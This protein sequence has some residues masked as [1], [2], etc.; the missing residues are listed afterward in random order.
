MIRDALRRVPRRTLAAAC[1]AAVLAW[2]LWAW[3]DPVTLF[4]AASWAAGAAGFTS[5]ATAL[6]Y[7][8]IAAAVYG[9]VTSRRQ[10]RAKAAAQRAAYNA[11]LE[12]RSVTLLQA[13]PPWRIVYG[14]SITGGDIVAI[15]TTDKTGTRSDATTY[16]KADA[17]KHLVIV[18]AAHECQAVNELYV[19]GVP[20][21]T[22]DGSGWVTAGEFYSTL[23][24]HREI[25]IVAGG[26]STQP[27]APT[28]LKSVRANPPDTTLPVDASYTIT[29]GG[30]T[31]NN[32]SG[33]NAV[34]TFTLPVPTPSVRAS[35]H[36][37]TAAQTVDAY[38]NGVA[39]TEWTAD[40]RL[41]GL[42]YSVV[43]LDLENPRFQGGPPNITADVSGRKVLDTRT[44]T[45]AYS[46]NP[47]L[48]VRD[49]LTAPWGY[50]CAAADIDTTACNTAANACDALITLTIGGS[51]TPNQPTYT[52]NGVLT[53]A[54]S[55]EALLEQLVA[56]MAGFAVY[57]AKW[58]I[59]AGAWTA[60]VLALTDDDLVGQIEIVQADA[61]LDEA[62][63]G[64]RGMHVPRGKAVPVEF[65]QYQNATFVAADGAELW[66]DIDLPWVDNK[67]RARNLARIFVE[68]A[69][70]A[71]AIRYPA[72]LRAWPLQVG[73]RVTV[74]S[75]E[76]G[77]ATKNFRVTDWQFG[78][79]SPVLLT[80]QEDEAA[81]YDLADAAT[82][83]PAPNTN[84]PNPWAVAALGGV[85]VASG[86]A[87]LVKL[88][89]GTIDT[90]AQV[91]WTAIADPY[92]TDGSGVVRLRWRRLARDPANLWHEIEV[93]GNETKAIIAGL[94][95]YDI[96]AIEAQAINGLG[97][98]GVPV[99]VVHT[100]VG[101]TAPPADVAS[102]AAAAITGAIRLTWAPNTEADYAAT[103]LRLGT[104]W[105]SG[106][107]LD[108]GAAG[109]TEVVGNAYLWA[110]PAPGSY[111]V[112]A[113]HRDTT[114]NLSTSTTSLAVTVT[115]TDIAVG[116]G[117]LLRN[118]S[119]E[120]DA[121]AD[122]LGDGW[123]LFTNGGAAVTYKVAGPD[124]RAH[125]A[126][127]QRIE[128]NGATGTS[129]FIFLRQDAEARGVIGG[130]PMVLSGHFQSDLNTPQVRL[131][132]GFYN[133]AA[134]LISSL[135]S[136]WLTL[137]G[138]QNRLQYAFDAPSGTATVRAE[139]VVGNVGNASASRIYIDALQLEIGRAMTAYAPRADE[140][141]AGQVGTVELAAEAA[142]GLATA[143][144]TLGTS[145]N[146]G[147]STQTRATATWVN[148]TGAA[149]QVQIEAYVPLSSLSWN[150]SPP[151]VAR[152]SYRYSSTT[153]GTVTRLMCD[154]AALQ[155]AGGSLLIG[156]SAEQ[157]TLPAGET[158]T[159]ELLWELT[160]TALAVLNPGAQTCATR[161]AA[162]K[163]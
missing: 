105:A 155:P 104:V 161:I 138:G 153:L 32:T 129:D 7:M 163:R 146:N 42:C 72:K 116:G 68:R 127:A 113:R 75:T 26:S 98:R 31:I 3:A 121:N 19:D 30:L 49:F 139:A 50:E 90:R 47:A 40:H 9:A 100:V 122:G 88:P 94:S 111:T 80:L 1:A 82:A 11:S 24:V 8:A 76:Y 39:A 131:F 34:V 140:I 115:A 70:N 10:A 6:A 57:G 20:L 12:D 149:V 14:R 143:T 62:F 21:G 29:G 99:Y 23:T 18:W 5:A 78:P 59:V 53:T 65:D 74:T 102:L 118:S 132:V 144:S 45:T 36:L 41:R 71:L 114:G 162:I 4:G 92:I 73:D 89:D 91:S 38:L 56:P 22:L 159:L 103:E 54:Q 16:T 28:V 69:R 2:P 133:A 112:M 84:L 158:L 120:V 51:S 95:A 107:R 96:L 13:A 157:V 141:L 123:A 46:E 148:A 35:H 55:R 37:G 135:T 130:G 154:N 83:D 97:A 79:R 17:L 137:S 85:S 110:W 66:S 156:A 124:G 147:T 145:V 64:V 61:G 33:F 77:F 109:S 126:L 58:H 108:T 119:F 63:N 87:H 134:S 150:V 117:N 67:A 81:A 86:T 142:T 101:K 136:A 60:P 43:T 15:F 152:V 25:T 52:C 48:I 128:F 151:S 106:T 27:Y 160:H 93:P 125:G 44:S